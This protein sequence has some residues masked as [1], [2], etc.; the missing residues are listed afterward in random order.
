MAQPFNKGEKTMT[1][2]SKPTHRAHIVRK[3]TDRATLSGLLHQGKLS[4][5]P[6]SIELFQLVVSNAFDLREVR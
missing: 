4:R 5:H 1:T 3:Y 2:N 6:V